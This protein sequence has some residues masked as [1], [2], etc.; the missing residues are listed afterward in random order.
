MMD[1]QKCPPGLLEI[2]ERF[3]FDQTQNVDDGVRAPE[4]TA[5][6]IDALKHR[7]FPE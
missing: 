5:A 1:K 6:I 4:M 7:Q 3:V 2:T